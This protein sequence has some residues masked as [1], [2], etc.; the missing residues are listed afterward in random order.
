MLKPTETPVVV[1][2]PFNRAG[3]SAGMT[4]T[5]NHEASQSAR[6]FQPLPFVFGQLWGNMG[7]SRPSVS[8]KQHRL[9]DIIS[10]MLFW[11]S[12][13]VAIGLSW[14]QY[15]I[16]Q[17]LDPVC[18]LSVGVPKDEVLGGEPSF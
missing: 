1:Q 12:R 8:E 2:C 18:C 16:V 11:M 17:R 13:L 10:G 14:V 5:S 3:A 15:L 4:Q 7:L 6:C 9:A